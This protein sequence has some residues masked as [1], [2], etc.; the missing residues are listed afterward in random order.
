MAGILRHAVLILIL[1]LILAM[2]G[3]TQLENTDSLSIAFKNPP[4]AA[5]PRVWWHWMNGN[6]T[7]EGI[8]AD[9][10]WMKRVGIAGAQVFDVD[11]HTPQVVS[12]PLNFMS[13]GWK[14]AFFH[15][16]QE[17]ERLGLE[18]GMASSG[19]WS[20]SGSPWVKPEEAMKR[21]VWSDTIVQGNGLFNGRVPCPE[22]CIISR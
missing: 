14:Q 13:D 16:G 10:E 20:E 21:I 7:R 1:L 3:Y 4:D 18:L 9:L 22:I 8:T 6:V 11:L 2:R 19:G 17:A 5:K 12:A 15:T